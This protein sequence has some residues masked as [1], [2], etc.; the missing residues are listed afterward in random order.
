MIS[1]YFERVNQFI[2]EHRQEGRNVLVHCTLGVSRSA[3]VLMAYL[4]HKYRL[5]ISLDT[6]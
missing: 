6:R 1:E 3:T 4:I 5:S 2:H